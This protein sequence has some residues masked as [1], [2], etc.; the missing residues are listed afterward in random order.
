MTWVGLTQLSETMYIAIIQSH[1]FLWKKNLEKSWLLKKHQSSNSLFIYILFEKVSDVSYWEIRFMLFQ[2]PPA[3]IS[4]LLLCCRENYLDLDKKT[5]VSALL[6]YC[7][8]KHIT[9]QRLNISSWCFTCINFW[10]QNCCFLLFFFNHNTWDS[11]MQV[12]VVAVIV[13]LL[14]L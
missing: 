8:N 6:F 2:R 13:V 7:R 4:Y 1:F 5:Q 14:L 12:I 9:I 11:Q 10:R 3:N